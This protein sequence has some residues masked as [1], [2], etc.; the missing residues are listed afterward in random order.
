MNQSNTYTSTATTAIDNSRK[1]G[2]ATKQFGASTWSNSKLDAKKLTSLDLARLKKMNQ[3]YAHVITGN[4]HLV[5]KISNGL[6]E[7]TEANFES[8]KDFKYRFLHEPQLAG[9][10]IGDAWLRWENKRYYPG[11]LEFS[12]RF[13]LESSNKDKFNLFRGFPLKPLAG[14]VEPFLF[15]VREVICKRD[16]NLTK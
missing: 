15:H 2:S 14:D 12:P 9:L 11:G 6:S 8:I 16:E 13:Q 3:Q 5:M 10:N 4:R 1:A 7:I